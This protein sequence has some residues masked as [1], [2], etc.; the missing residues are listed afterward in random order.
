MGS[1]ARH[2]ALM[3]ALALAAALVAPSLAPEGPEAMFLRRLV[4]RWLPWGLFAAGAL[5]ALAAWRVAAYAPRLRVTY[6]MWLALPATLALAA[7][8]PGLEQ[9]SYAI[10]FVAA[11]ALAIAWF[12]RGLWAT[13]GSSTEAETGRLLGLGV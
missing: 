1:A 10:P 7:L 4:G 12:V 5:H 3:A 2:V 9:T 13:R 6:L 8:A 11:L